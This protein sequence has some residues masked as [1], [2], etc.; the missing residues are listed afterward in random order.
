MVKAHERLVNLALFLASR[1]RPVTVEECRTAGLGYPSEADDAAFQR[2]F[3]RD[4]DALRA[5]GVAIVTHEDGRYSVDAERSFASTVELDDAECA[6]VRA[7][8]AALMHDPAFPFAEDLGVAVAKMD[9]GPF[10]GEP[11]SSEL[12][13]ADPERQ[14]AHARLA[15]DAVARRKRLTFDYTNARG[16]RRLHEV[17]PYG[18]AYRRGRWYL[19]ARDVDIDEVRVYALLRASDLR[20]DPVSPKSPDF[21]LPDGFALDEHLVLPFQIGPRRFEAAARFAPEAAWR[22]PALTEGKGRLERG[23]DGS[24]RWLVEAASPIAFAAWCAEH[25]P[26]VVPLEP[27]EAVAAYREGLAEVMALHG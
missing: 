13:V 19:I 7:V 6:T 22:A 27:A 24:V 12:A 3:E 9:L 23:S 8:A 11:A 21:D 18:V 15:A 4:K 14:S 26:G 25:G 16:E 10:P 2:M 20:V 17:E 1:T 5:A